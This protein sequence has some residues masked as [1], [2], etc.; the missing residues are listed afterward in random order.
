MRPTAS[1]KSSRKKI[2]AIIPARMESSRFPGKPLCKIC[3]HTMIEHVLRRVQRAKSLTDVVVATCNEEIVREVERVGGRAIMTSNAHVRCTD[4]IE[5]AADKIGGD[6]VVNVQGDEPFVTPEMIDAAVQPMLDEPALV[7]ANL[8]APITDREAL[9]DPNEVKVVFDRKMNALYMSREPIPSLK[10]GG[11]FD[12]A[13][14]QVCVIPFTMEFLHTF[15]RLAPTPL[16]IRESVDMMRAIEH[17]YP[18]RMVPCAV[19]GIS[20]DTEADRQDAEAAMREDPLF[21][22][23]F[24]R[25]S[26]GARQ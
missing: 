23:L 25:A 3:G 26:P 7:C 15:S 1:S 14:K 21:Q 20:V 16:E 11:A 12:H 19:R 18:V 4:R 17:G 24:G 13:W 10:K 22:K 5:E 8:M 9:E 6:I 2:V